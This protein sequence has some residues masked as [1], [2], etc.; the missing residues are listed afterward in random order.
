MRPTIYSYD[1]V[2][3]SVL[4]G[5]TQWTLIYRGFIRF[6]VVS[7]SSVFGGVMFGGERV[8]EIP[9]IASWE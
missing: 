6:G 3:F 2:A 5:D 8:V 4:A 1:Q 7:F 9:M